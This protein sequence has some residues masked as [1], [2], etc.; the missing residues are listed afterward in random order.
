VDNICISTDDT[1]VIQYANQLGVEVPFVR[2]PNLTTDSA[3]SYDVLVHALQYYRDNEEKSFE[4]VV[5][6]QPTS[7]FRTSVH[8]DEACEVALNNP[9]ADMI[10]AVKES[11]A[12]PYFN[13]F[14]ES[15][16]GELKQSKEGLFTR[17]Q[18]VPKVYEFN[19]SIYIIKVTSLLSQK[20][21][22]KLDRIIKYEMSLE[23][24]MD[25]DTPLDLLIA[26]LLMEKGFVEL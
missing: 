15:D 23:S 4:Y 9:E 22:G 13:L 2:P 14:E 19:G 18:D 11:K 10:V 1:E 24:S 16:R 5:L 26:N 6:L 7:P 12:N 21:I 3:S 25:I 20:T 8:I 17:R